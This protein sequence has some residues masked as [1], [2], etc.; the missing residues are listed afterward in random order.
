MLGMHRSST[1]VELSLTGDVCRTYIPMYVCMTVMYANTLRTGK[2]PT[3]KRGSME[4]ASCWHGACVQVPQRVAVHVVRVLG[5]GKGRRRDAAD[6]RGEGDGGRTGGL[7]A[8]MRESGKRTSAHCATDDSD[9]SCMR[10]WLGTLASVRR[11]VARSSA[12]STGCDSCC[13][14]SAGAASPPDAAPLASAALPPSADVCKLISCSTGACR[15]RGGSGHAAGGG[16]AT[17]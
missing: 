2:H 12:S 7:G 10:M 5:H 6:D 1:R 4:S 15:G 3:W 8:P 16:A 11:A 9:G 17:G 13:C 14:E